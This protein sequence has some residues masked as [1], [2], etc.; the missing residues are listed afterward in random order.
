[1]KKIYLI[2]SFVSILFLAW[3]GTNTTQNID[4]TTNNDTNTQENLNKQQDTTTDKVTTKKTDETNDIKNTETQNEGT[5]T[6][7]YENK[8]DNFSFEFMSGRTFQENKY[9]FTTVVFTPQ[10]DDIKENV[11]IAIQKLQKYLSV[12]EYYEETKSKLENTIVWFQEINTKDITQA[13]LEWKTMTY[14]YQEWELTL[15]SQQTFLIAENNT[16]YIINYTATAD[17][18]DTFI[19]W[20]NIIIDSFTLN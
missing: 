17:T 14:E 20:V 2:A 8:T 5:N 16:V 1:M 11:W 19:D 3:C 7:I 10:D 13:G 6:R 12:Q 4:D 9:W 15:K 18:F